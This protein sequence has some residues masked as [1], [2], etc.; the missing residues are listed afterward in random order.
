MSNISKLFHKQELLKSRISKI[1]YGSI[2][3]R[4]KNNR[5]LYK[6]SRIR[7]SIER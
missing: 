4:E 6:E 2:E 7:R 5:K 1:L 3:I